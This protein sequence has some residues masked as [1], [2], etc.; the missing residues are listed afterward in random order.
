M[1]RAPRRWE[2]ADGAH[3]IHEYRVFL[4]HFQ[5]RSVA[6][7]IASVPFGTNFLVLPGGGQTPISSALTSVAPFGV[8]LK[9][10]ISFRCKSP[11]DHRDGSRFLI[12]AAANEHGAHTS[13]LANV[14]ILDARGP[15][16]QVTQATFQDVNPKI[17]VVT[18]RLAWNVPNVSD[19]DS[20]AISFMVYCSR[21][22]SFCFRK[23]YG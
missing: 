21:R 4:A 5:N 17:G 6:R 7:Q 16:L 13:N 20:T 10:F 14:R 11:N 1:W 19:P 12:V 2:G 18:G 3:D 8:S 15:T 9:F 23:F 22:W